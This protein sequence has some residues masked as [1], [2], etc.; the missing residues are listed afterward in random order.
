MEN[1][2]E[3]LKDVT[4]GKVVDKTILHQFIHTL[5]IP[6]YEKQRMLSLTP[7]NYI[8]NSNQMADNI[9][10]FIKDAPKL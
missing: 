7:A 6:L 10:L 8:G 4:R 3:K 1:A 2:Y 9:K 5:D